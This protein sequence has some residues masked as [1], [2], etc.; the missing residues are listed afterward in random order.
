MRRRRLPSRRSGRNTSLALREQSSDL[1]YLE[2]V[3]T[4]QFPINSARV[5]LQRSM[6]NRIGFQLVE[7]ERGETLGTVRCVEIRHV[8]SGE[9]TW[10]W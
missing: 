9:K 6:G 5:Y 1:R 2:E 8:N 3:V 4:I 10:S 7:A